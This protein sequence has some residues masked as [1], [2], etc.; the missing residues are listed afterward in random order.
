MCL[1]LHCAKY[2]HGQVPFYP[3]DI[4]VRVAA[5]SNQSS[6]RHYGHHAP[7]NPGSRQVIV[8]KILGI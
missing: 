6:D 4:S 5:G 7:Y 1:R 8:S 3:K 2:K